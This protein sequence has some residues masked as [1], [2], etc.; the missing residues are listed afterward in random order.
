MQKERY[1]RVI[2]PLK[3]LYD[4]DSKIL[5][6]GSFPSVKSREDDFFYANP[7]NRFWKLLFVLLEEKTAMDTES[8]KTILTKH[9]IALYDVIYKCDI[10][11]SMDS[12]IKNVEPTN[13][14]PIKEKS[15]LKMIFCNGNLSHRY[16]NKYHRNVLKMEAMKLPGTSSANARYKLEDL[17]ESWKII[18]DYLKS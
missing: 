1:E 4:E 11:G 10:V 7:Q 18:L 12:S 6:L 3:P 9:N 17:I 15:D 2:H 16:Y 5:I 14:K 8:K 13:L